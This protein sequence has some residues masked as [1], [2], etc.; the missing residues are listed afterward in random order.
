MV[1]FALGWHFGLGGLGG[2]RGCGG[3]FGDGD[4]LLLF[5]C[6][7]VGRLLRPG[8]GGLGFLGL[9]APGQLY[10]FS[11]D[12][13]FSSCLRG[14]LVIA[15]PLRICLAG[16]LVVALVVLA[17][18]DS[19]GQS[20]TGSAS[21]PV[22]QGSQVKDLSAILVDGPTFVDL[23]ADSVTVKLDTSIPVVCAAAYGTTTSYGELATDAN[24]GG[25]GHTNHLPLLGGLQPDTEYHLRMQGVGADGTLYRSKDYTFKTPPAQQGGSKPQGT[26]L[27]LLANGAK[28]TGVSS[29]YGGGDNN[30]AYGAN[31]AFDGD[32]TTQ[33]SSNGD[34]N[35]AW[36]EIKLASPAH[37]TAIG[38]WTR[39]MGSS[40]QINSFR[41]RDDGGKAYGP[42]KLDDA[43]GIHYFPV[44]FTAETLRF[45]AVDTSGGN[46]GAVEIEVY[47]Q[48]QPAR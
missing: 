27:A 6:G 15:I 1:H 47:G 40:A 12:G 44:D 39:T 46:T 20:A 11:R 32:P 45:E 38:F 35:N 48:A 42:F 7:L 36:V 13:S 17:G 34:G 30:S 4:G 2:W 26:N 29:N 43:S 23:K 21:T 33:W 31:H 37:V 10:Y 3:R 9:L 19:A 25:T 22:S 28:V 14:C 5:A 18:C 16:C 41:V 8:L 24:M